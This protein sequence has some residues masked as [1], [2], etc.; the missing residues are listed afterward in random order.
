[1]ASPNDFYKN[2]E[3][4]LKRQEKLASEYKYKAFAPLLSLMQRKEYEENLPQI[5]LNRED[6]PLY[7]LDGVL[8]A[9]KWDRIVIG[10]YGAFIEIADED[11][12]KENVKVKRGEEYRINDEHYSKRV[13][14]FWY[15]PINGY[16]TKIY[17]Q[18]K[19]VTYADYQPGKWYASP[20]EVYVKEEM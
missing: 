7:S 4:M 15:V 8:L 16:P 19:T 13:K 14:Y 18:Q 3:K 9:K 17:F 12:V 11:V 1:M 6:S 10:D 20:Y 2:G 5:F